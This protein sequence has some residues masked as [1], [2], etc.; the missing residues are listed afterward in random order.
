[1][2]KFDYSRTPPTIRRRNLLEFG[3]GAFGAGVAAAMLPTVAL[4]ASATDPALIKAAKAEGRLN[5]IA[6]PPDWANYRMIIATFEKQYGITVNS[7]APGESSAQELQSIRSL[8]GQSRAPDVVDVGPS[9]ALSGTSAG[10]FTPYKVNTWDSIP[11]NMKDPGGM[12]YGDYF[13]VISFGVNRS[14]A[15]TAPETWAD[16][17]KPEY[18]GMVA[19]GGSP[20]GASSAFG[21]VM[22]AAIAEGGS[23]NDIMP[24]IQFFADLAKLGNFNPSSATT[25][26]L[27]SGQT[28]VLLNW[29]YLNLARAK[30]A[31]GMVVIDTIIPANAKPYGSYYCQ[32]ISKYAPHPK[33]AELWEEFLY[34]DQGQLL[35]LEGFAHP[36]RFSDMVKRGVISQKLMAELPPPG[37]YAEALFTTASEN[38]KAQQMLAANWTKMVGID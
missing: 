2:P 36:V 13:G 4:G 32:A 1:M 6:L 19:M 35:F 30:K 8:K 24:G 14:V 12:W 22:A 21:A 31:K 15:K 17:K 33:A 10:L 9:F 29:D 27:F 20:L 25:A 26:S 28:P 18:K 16:L 5:T 38:L 23:P 3:V 37:P 7:A 11:A 34:S